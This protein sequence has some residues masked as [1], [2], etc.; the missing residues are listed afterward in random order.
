MRGLVVDNCGDRH[1]LDLRAQRTELL[2]LQLLP[3]QAIPFL[4]VVQM[5][6]SLRRHQVTDA[7]I[8]PRGTT[9]SLPDTALVPWI[10]LATC[11]SRNPRMDFRTASRTYALM[12]MR[13]SSAD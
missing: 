1:T 13:R 12:D 5:A 7:D 4:R 9:A 6:V 11:S 10:S 2:G 8:N 3:A